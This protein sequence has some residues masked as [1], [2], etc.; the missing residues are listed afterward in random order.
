MRPI[1]KGASPQVFLDY[2][3]AK[4][5]L[6]DR[7]GTYC[8]FCERLI[9]TGLAVEHI[10]PKGR[11]KYAHLK[12]E[13][14]NFLL[15][16]VNCNS[17]K[18]KKDVTTN[19]FLLPDRDNTFPFFEYDEL[20]MVNPIGTPATRRLAKKTID[21]VALNKTTHKKWDEDTMRSALERFSQRV[22][23]WVQAKEAR[24]D[25]NKGEVNVRR[26]ASEAASTGFFSIWLKAFEGIAPVRRAIINLYKNTAPDC[27]DASANPINP[28]PRNG[29]TN[30]GKS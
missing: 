21:L 13:W 27:F 29:L 3:D 22:Q 17:A 19:N 18:S 23:V 30:S 5:F 20:G 28:R 12:N 26:I 14:N 7:L 1:D 6:T 8:S 15:C 2:R 24:E 4:P 11:K 25:Y 9:L 16:C 10:Q